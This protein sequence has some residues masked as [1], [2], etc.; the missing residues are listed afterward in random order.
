MLT[1]PVPDLLQKL[2]ASEQTPLRRSI[3][4]LLTPLA[5]TRL[6]ESD[7][8]FNRPLLS[9]AEMPEHWLGVRQ[10][11]LVQSKICPMATVLKV[12]R[13]FHHLCSD[14]IQMDVSHQLPQVPIRLTE[15]RLVAALKEVSDLS[16]RDEG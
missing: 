11:G 6:D 3:I 12:L 14:R 1:Y 15:N 5:Q 2:V 10:T 8:N 7:V 9:C 13:P 4:V 16:N